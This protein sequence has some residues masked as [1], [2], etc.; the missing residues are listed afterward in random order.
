VNTIFV[1]LA[2]TPRFSTAG[3]PSFNPGF[4]TYHSSGFT[5]PCTTPSPRPYAAVTNTASVN[6]DS[7]SMVNITPDAPTSDRTIR[8]TPADNATWSWSNP[9]CTR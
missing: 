3:L 2:P 8:C 9:W 6:P 1:A 4:H 7:V 5:A